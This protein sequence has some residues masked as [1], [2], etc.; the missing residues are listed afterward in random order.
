[1]AQDSAT[2]AKSIFDLSMS[3]CEPA[4]AL[5][6]VIEALADANLQDAHE[7]ESDEE[8]ER[9]AKAQLLL[10]QLATWATGGYRWHEEFD[11]SGTARSLDRAEGEAK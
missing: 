7:S 6:T 1:M 9:K 10:F 3:F 2:K 8:Y 4:I 5:R 11:R